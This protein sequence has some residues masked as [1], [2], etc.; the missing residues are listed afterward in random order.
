MLRNG[1]KSSQQAASPPV[2]APN[3]SQTPSSSLA[4]GGY[5][6]GL[7]PLPSGALQPAS[8]PDGDAGHRVSAGRKPSEVPP[9]PPVGLS[10][11][12]APQVPPPPPRHA[13]PGSVTRGGLHPTGGAMGS[14]AAQPAAAASSWAP[15]A[16]SG[17]YTF[18]RPAGA[19]SDSQ[20]ACS[21][22]CSGRRIHARGPRAGRQGAEH[23]W[24]T[25]VQVA[26]RAAR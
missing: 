13:P 24:Q 26:A 12:P 6:R 10:G 14:G 17:H 20:W 15:P 23:G 11:A 7:G 9:P 5:T 4:A 3:M 25:R 16:P 1:G 21:T 8:S 2:G 19:S 18:R 22:S